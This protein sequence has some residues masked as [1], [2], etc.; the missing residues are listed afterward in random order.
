M[1]DGKV[2]IWPFAR[3]E[4]AKRNSVNRTAG[5]LE[6]KPISVD[7]EVY[8][9]M[10]IDNVLPAIQEKWPVATKQQLIRIQQDN[11]P[12]H[13]KTDDPI[14]QAAV[15]ATGLTI[16]LYNQPPNSPDTNINDLA[17]FASIQSLQHK[18]LGGVTKDSLVD[19]VYQAYELYPWKKLRNAFLTLKCCLNLIIECNGGNDYKIVH[20]SKDRLERAGML[21]TNIIVTKEAQ[22]WIDNRHDDIDNNNEQ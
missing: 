10:L 13:I 12:V 2:G 9:A 5:T 18:I 20:M 22:H 19:A 17:F 4:A 14:F 3:R 11:A 21:P 16:E 6:W 15:E 7:R 1:W 8:R